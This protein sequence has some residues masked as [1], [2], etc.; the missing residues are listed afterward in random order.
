MASSNS[1]SSSATWVKVKNRL[2]RCGNGKKATLRVLETSNN[3][4]RLFFS[5]EACKY[6]KWLSP[7]NE[8]WESIQ[9]F[10]SYDIPR[11]GAKTTQF[12]K[13][14]AKYKKV[15]ASLDLVKFIVLVHTVLIGICIGMTF[16]C[17]K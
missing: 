17:K 6:F 11:I 16:N 10:T 9:Q 4:K 2:C 14:N 3:P 5:C 12:H 13:V 8:E 1:T 7:D 15:Q